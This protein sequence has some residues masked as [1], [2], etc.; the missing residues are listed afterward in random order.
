MQYRK[1]G[2]SDI[3]VSAI[4]LGLMTFGDQTD[5]IDAFAQL[6][7]ALAAGITLYD[8][9]ENY[10]APVDARTQGRSEAI[11]GKWINS[12][13]IRDQVIVATKVSGPGNDPGDMTHIRGDQ[14]CLDK[15]NIAAAI[16]A[17]LQRIGTDYIDLYQVHWPERPVT[18]LRRSRY[19]LI[20]DAPKQVPI[21]ET[22]E[23]LAGQVQSG[24]VRQIGVCN[25]SPWGV[26][27]YLALAEQQHSPRIV[28]IQNS[29]SLLDRLFEHGLAE[30]AI[31]E[32]VGLIGYSPL[33]GGIL[34]GKYQA[35]KSIEGSRSSLFKGF[36]RRFS[37]AV[38]E[39]S[40]RYIELAQQHGVSP[41]SLALSFARQQPFMSSVLIAA[42]SVA[43]LDKNLQCVDLELPKD[44]IKA[45]NAI[46][47][48]FPNPK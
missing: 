5:E 37:P 23:A 6:D 31:R 4:G 15:Q 43:Q 2:C 1:L 33:A 12:R 44:A 34:T 3:E 39:A 24:K 30:I 11:L 38:L 14:R 22:L 19:S 32:K 21:E 42:S 9:A 18:T 48:S 28:S 20:P 17:S 46:H 8:T 29:Y 41:A 10:P 16:D 13:G 25:E 35:A 45:I 7:A 40:Q 27:R 47:D 36:D 26:M